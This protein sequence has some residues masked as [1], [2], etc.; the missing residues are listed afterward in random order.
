MAEINVIRSQEELD[1]LFAASQENPVVIFKH[2]RTCG[3]SLDIFEQVKNV[4]GTINVVVVQESRPLSDNIAERTGYRHHSPQAFVIKNGSVDYH[5]THYA[6]DPSDIQ[7][8]IG[9][10][11]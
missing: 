3:I 7:K 8:K 11:E 10:T 1:G 5:A 4:D 9:V 6:I 2:S